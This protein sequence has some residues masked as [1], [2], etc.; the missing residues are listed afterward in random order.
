MLAG[1]IGIVA[2]LA[3]ALAVW[4]FYCA[5]TPEV[6]TTHAD[7]VDPF[8]APFE[9]GNQGNLFELYSVI[10][11]C[12]IANL[13]LANG[14]GMRNMSLAVAI[15]AANIPPRRT[16]RYHC[17]LDPEH[18]NLNVRS[19]PVRN[20]DIVIYGTYQLSLFGHLLAHRFRFQSDLLH[21]E[22]GSDG[23]PYWTSGTLVE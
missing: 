4:E 16:A 22:I 17:P 7:S 3:S 1:A 8:S 5:L 12:G 20:A 9:I 6:S 18:L 23:T 13:S 10:P 14:S 11:T 2:F 19:N 15:Q 21:W